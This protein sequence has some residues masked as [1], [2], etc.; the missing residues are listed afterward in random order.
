MVQPS[1]PAS[2]NSFENEQAKLDFT[3]IVIHV[4]LFPPTTL[5]GLHM[6]MQEYLP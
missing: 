3:I 1:M 5:Y 2:P 6:I 4:F